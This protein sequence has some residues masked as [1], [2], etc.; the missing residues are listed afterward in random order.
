MDLA[1]RPPARATLSQV[2]LPGDA[3]PY[4]NVH[5]G[6]IMK[7]VDTAGAIAAHR[8]ARRRVVTIEI[9]SMTFLQ[10]VHVGDLVTLEARVTAVWRTSIET[11]VEVTAENIVTGE[12]R[13]TSTAFVVYVA[14]DEAGRPTPVPPLALTTPEEHALARAAEARR[15]RRLASRPDLAD[16]A[17]R[18][19]RSD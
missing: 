6:T 15:Q 9:D 18:G 1:P 8:H 13:H 17:H 19:Y 7:L 4:G 3:N 2:M 14:L 16:E 11:L 10:P 12:V 5:G